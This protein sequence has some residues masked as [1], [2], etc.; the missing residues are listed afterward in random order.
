MSHETPAEDK[1]TRDKF[2]EL[3]N[4]WIESSIKA[5]DLNL[6]KRSLEKLLTEE[7]ME[8]LE[9]AHS[10]AQ[11]FMANEL[12]NKTQELRAKYQLNEQMERFD[13]LIKNAKNKP[14]IEKR[15]LPAPEQIVNS[16]I[17]EAKENE[18]VRLQQEYDD[19]KAKNSELMDQLII[20]KKEFRD[21]IQHI[22]DTINETERGCEVASNIPVSEMIEL[23]E[24]MK[25]LNNS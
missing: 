21:Q 19:I 18:L 24:K 4:K 1:T 15:V 6:L 14:P 22:Q 2:D 10:Q 8:E 13:E 25:H 17:H 11:D 23:T 7:S 5:F 3:T 16:I 9:N 20:Q 12:R